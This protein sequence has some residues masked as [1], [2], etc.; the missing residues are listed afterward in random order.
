MKKNYL[1]TASITISIFFSLASCSKNGDKNFTPA[2]QSKVSTEE[3]VAEKGANPDE[4][5]IKQNLQSLNTWLREGDSEHYLYTESNAAANNEILVYKIKRDGS[6]YF[7]GS[8]MS[9]CSGTG[10]PLGSQGALELDKN[11]KWP[12]AV[13]AGSNSVSSFKVQDDGSLTLAHTEGSKGK[14]PVSLSVHDNMLYVLNRG[15]DNIHGFWIGVGGTLTDIEGSTQSLSG[16][17]VDA[18]QISF[19]PDVDWIAVTEKATNIITTFKVKQDRSISKGIFTPSISKTPFGFEF[20]RNRFMIVSNAVGG[21]AAAGLASSYLTGNNGVPENINGAVP[22]FE[23]APC[24]V[25]VTKYGRFAYITNTASNNISTYYVDNQSALYLVQKEAAKTN[26]GPLD[27]VVAE[28]NYFVYELNSKSNTIG[29]YHRKLM[30]KLEFIS[31]GVNLPAPAT[32]LAA[33]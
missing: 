13:N 18:P 19:M 20:S 3:I 10:K 2:T 31:S 1:L 22:N 5:T 21:R 24:W 11:N 17:A 14:T 33:Y 9:G 7:A 12:F 6:L 23:S 30:G 27:I 32:G 16:T 25:A 29:G 8:T 28:N 15:S 26:G 4:E